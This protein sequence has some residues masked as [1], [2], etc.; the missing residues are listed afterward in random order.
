MLKYLVTLWDRQLTT[1]NQNK[2][3]KVKRKWQ[4]IKKEKYGVIWRFLYKLKLF[5]KNSTIFFSHVNFWTKLD[6]QAHMGQY[7]THASTTL[8]P[9]LMLQLASPA[10]G[11]RDS[12]QTLG[13]KNESSNKKKLNWPCLWWMGNKWHIHMWWDITTLLDSAEQVSLTSVISR[14]KYYGDRR[15]ATF[16]NYI[17]ISGCT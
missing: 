3:Q 2:F 13:A 1:Q 15:I 8:C 9:S 6:L 12:M 17:L 5:E 14:D 4:K 11:G 7:A 10:Q 16:F